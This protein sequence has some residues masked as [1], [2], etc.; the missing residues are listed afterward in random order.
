MGQRAVRG[1]TWLIGLPGL[2]GHVTPEYQGSY[3][4]LELL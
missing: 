2:E 4:I 3:A 1:G